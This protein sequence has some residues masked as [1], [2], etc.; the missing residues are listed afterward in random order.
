M[1]FLLVATMLFGLLMLTDNQANL[2][3]FMKKYSF[4]ML[5]KIVILMPIILHTTL[6]RELKNQDLHGMQVHILVQVLLT[7][8]AD[9]G[10]LT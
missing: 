4:K 7:Q 8:V 2:P 10:Q 9:T 3:G 5:F 1:I 6:L